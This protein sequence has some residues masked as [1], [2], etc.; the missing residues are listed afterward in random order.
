[1]LLGKD[2]VYATRRLLGKPGFLAIALLT[3]ALGVGFNAAIFT[4]VNAFLIKPLPIE[5]PNRVVTLNFGKRQSGPQAS[6]PDYLDIRDRN[7]V[8]TSVAAMRVMPAALSTSST[9]ATKTTREWGFL[10]SGN[11]FNLLGVQPVM[12]RFI[13][14]EDDGKSPSHVVVLGY[15]LWQR[16]FGADPSVVG[17]DVKLNGER[18]T[19]I[20][21]A[22]RGFIGTERFY[23]AQMWVPFSVIRT[24]EGRD[25]RDYRGTHNA[26]LIGRLDPGISKQ[27]AE[28][29]LAVLA[30]QI[31]REHRDTNEGFTI[32][33]SVPGL[34]GNLLRGPVL[35]IGLALLV[36]AL[37][38][39]LVACTNLSGLLLAH[40]ADR[41]KEMAIR[42]AI[43]AG[44]GVIVRMM[45]IESLLLG[46][47]G[48]LLGLIT[49]VW[50]SD[51]I[52]A[53]LPADQ[54]PI[55]HFSVDWRV[56]AFGAA[57]ALLT[58]MISAVVPA[59]RA[60]VVDVAPALKNEAAAGFT[61]GLHLRD[62]YVGVQITVCMILL[63]GSAMMIRTLHET[64][65]MRFGF[66]PGH[67]VVLRM[68]M[69][70]QGFDRDRGRAFQ[71]ELIEKI[72]QIP[73]T[74]SAGLSNSIPLS[75]DQS[76]ANVLAEGKPVPKLSD[77]MN[78]ILYQS[79][80]GYFRA[81]GTRLLAG[82]DFEERDRENSPKVV[83]VNQTLAD[84]LLPGEDALG[85]RIRIGSGGEPAQIV[86]IAENGRYETISEDPKPAAWQPMEQFY[87]TSASV[88][89]RSR[90]SSSEALAGARRVIASINPEMAVFDAQP[91]E[92]VLAFPLAP[93]RIST[94]ALTAMGALA[95]LLCALG[96]YGLLAYSAVQ[97]TR[98]IGIRMALGAR[99]R[100]VIGVLMS[101][102]LILVGASGAAGLIV[103]VF[104]TRVLGQFLYAK[105]DPSIYGMVAA[106]L[107]AISIIATTIPAVRVLR[108]RPLEAL[109]QE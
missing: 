35:G 87:N 16:Q 13:A 1:M 48:A 6:Y 14:P 5:D 86:G 70:L 91:L 4:F 52:Q 66:D 105:S 58:A 102:A 30:S 20:G 77:Q 31:E 18:F 44:R 98:E 95:A 100:N 10:V 28:A 38:T 81:M 7:Q 42:L 75:I 19:V 76:S 65:A 54:F 101:R 49:A 73:G 83:I 9:G 103:S 62:F 92:E 45:L 40:A 96:L 109:R 78:A 36:V 8:F 89:L 60:G 79:G 57:A 56:L 93:L 27:Q 82:R 94:A 68:D 41:R 106:L 107:V 51:G 21:V 61:R 22:P 80:P 71:R 74:E 11:Y 39:L 59:M 88:I 84:K 50:L 99:P 72:R 97:R 3:L 63:A 17:K 25:W 43:G 34:G 32:R 69:A 37:L 15:G 33:L 26:W 24:I 64:V 53:W 85:K 55:A 12:G 108:I 90:L 67:T 23:A 46:V 29:S 47:A 2:F 104:A